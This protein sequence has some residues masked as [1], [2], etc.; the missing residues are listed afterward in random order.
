MNNIQIEVIPIRK[1]F[2]DSNTY[3]NG[4]KIYSCRVPQ[5][6]ITFVNHNS[7]FITIKGIFQELNENEKYS[8][9]LTYEYNEKYQNSY[10]VNKII[11]EN[12]LL[13]ADRNRA[14]LTHLKYSESTIEN[15]LIAYPDICD[16]LINGKRNEIDINKIK[17]FNNTNLD[18]LQK[19]LIKET[20]EI[21]I[22]INFPEWEFTFAIAKSIT[23]KFNNDIESFKINLEKDPY[24]TLCDLDGMGFKK[25][26]KLILQNRSELISS[27]YRLYSA[28]EYILEQNEMQGSTYLEI[29]LVHKELKEIAPECIH[30]LEKVLKNDRFYIDSDK[31]SISRKV[32]YKIELNIAK[33]LL[34]GNEI[35]KEYSFKKE[36]YNQ[37]IE[38]DTL[39]D[40]QIVIL[41][42]SEKYSVSILCGYAGSGKTIGIKALTQMLSDNGKSFLLLAPTGKA[43]KVLSNAT[44]YEASTIHRVLVPMGKEDMIDNDFV[45][46]DEATM[47]DLFL[48]N[49][50]LSRIDFKKTSI[51]F[52]CDPAQLP[53]VGCGNILTNII[54][55]KMFPTIFLDKIFRYGEGGLSYVA[56]EIR[57]GNSYFKD[58][59]TSQEIIKFGKKSDYLFVNKQDDDIIEQLKSF[60]T[61]LIKNDKL[62]IDEITTLTSY[63][64]GSLGSSILN[65]IIQ[66]LVNPLTEENKTNFQ[67]IENKVPIQFRIGDKVIQVKNNYK[68]PLNIST[69]KED[70]DGNVEI[71]YENT[72]PVFNGEEGIVI[73]EENNALII[74]FDDRICRYTKDM[75]IEILLGYSITI[76]KS[77]GSTYQNVIVVSPN[78][79]SFFSSRNLLYVAL[80][81]ARNR[82]FHVGNGNAINRAIKKDSNIIRKT[83]LY[84]FLINIDKYTNNKE[85]NNIDKL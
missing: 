41:D 43:S 39:T 83:L 49:N 47:I 35:K 16:L 64:K 48:M 11:I 30:H 84:D 14:I 9:D 18:N 68:V 72:V 4:F 31:K 78:A 54:D 66:D 28:I 7:G 12:H 75:L 60:Y 19:K 38:G 70:Y 65:N 27:E 63:K 71:V 44:G 33:K 52:I 15:L 20:K 5:E 32:T 1:V 6:Y 26:D 62:N 53:S 51:I 40:K 58:I 13:E 45:I 17:G 21:Y 76:H 81:R 59:D 80:T 57:N 55:S 23:K 46:V 34:Q 85:I 77:Q 3:N 8:M 36:K 79:H 73:S 74:Q 24:K 42:F 61:N 29:L 50:L 67:K 25:T 2:D 69:Q 56:T 37:T 22:L 82:V 10:N